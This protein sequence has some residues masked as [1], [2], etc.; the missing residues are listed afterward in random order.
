MFSTPLPRFMTPT[1]NTTT[2]ATTPPAPVCCAPVTPPYVSYG[3][4]SWGADSPAQY[5]M[6]NTYVLDSTGKGSFRPRFSYAEIHHVSITGLAPG[7]VGIPCL[8]FL[9]FALFLYWE[10]SCSAPVLLALSPRG[11]PPS[12]TMS[13]RLYRFDAV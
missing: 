2:T 12:L 8:S 4:E 6:E 9:L 7:E 1:T 3:A 5:N 13:H 10:S 11:V